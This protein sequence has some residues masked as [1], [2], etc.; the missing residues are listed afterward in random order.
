MRCLTQTFRLRTE[1][2]PQFL[3][4]TDQVARVV[5]E[6]AVRNGFV[7]VFS[8]HTT[9]AVRINENCPH[10]LQDMEDMLRRIAP[11][12]GEYRHNVYA[13]AF[14]VNG[15]RPNGHSH[16][17]HLL[18]G[19]SEAVPVVDG[20]LLLGQYQ[21]IFFVELDHGRDREVVVQ[22]MGE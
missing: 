5:A 18:L 17:Q 7:V 22:V 19:A 14:S 16:C 1:R 8:R 11:P 13:H 6:A 9:A 15:E 10:L 20:R 3:D 12:E 21:R 2:G 4:I